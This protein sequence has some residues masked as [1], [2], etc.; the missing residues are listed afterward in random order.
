MRKQKCKEKRRGGVNVDGEEENE[1]E[2]MVAEAEVEEVDDGKSGG[3][4][5]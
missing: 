2:E 1:A 4:R 5:K 3:E